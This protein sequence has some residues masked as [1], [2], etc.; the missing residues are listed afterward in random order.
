MSRAGSDGVRSDT[1]V[2][3]DVAAPA[4]RRMSVGLTSTC[5][6]TWSSDGTQL[7]VRVIEG[8]AGEGTAWL[9]HATGF[10]GGTWAP[11]VELIHDMVRRI[12]VW[13]HRGHGR[14][15]RG[16]MPVSWWDMCNDTLDIVAAVGPDPGPAVVIGH[17]MGGAAAVMAELTRPGTFDAMVLVEPILL[18]DPIRRTPY[19][20]ADVVRKRRRVFESREKARV[21]F[22]RKAPFT[23]WHPSAID[24]YLDDG[25]READGAVSLACL[26][27]YEAD[28]YDAAHAHGAFRMLH[29]LDAPAVVIVGERSDTYE[30]DWARRIVAAMPSADLAIVAGGD[31]FIPMSHPGLVAREVRGALVGAAQNAE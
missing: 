16:T 13:D 17:S 3:L 30:L 2:E 24:G 15:Q 6:D 19:P 20:L 4:T 28:V 26:P 1:P 18:G 23:R 21:N 11:I 12:V 14:S 7:A 31:H 25:L 10:N 5:F 29:H 27:E 9:S 8:T 22:G